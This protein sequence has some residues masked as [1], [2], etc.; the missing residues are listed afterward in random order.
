MSLCGLLGGVCRGD[1]VFS[2]E[3]WPLRRSSDSSVF[4][5]SDSDDSRVDGARDTVVQ[6]VVCLG[7]GVLGVDRGLGQV[8]DGGG[9]DDVPDRHALDGLVLG[10]GF[11]AVNASDGL[12]VASALLVSTVGGSLLRH[13]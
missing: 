12:D 2:V 4:P 6:L 13:G 11:R 9:L 10:D 1:S 5:G 7:Q 3:S 8:S